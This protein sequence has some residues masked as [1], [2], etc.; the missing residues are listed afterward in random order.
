[1]KLKA[2]SF[3]VSA[4]PIKPSIMLHARWALSKLNHHGCCN[5]YLLLLFLGPLNQREVGAA[6]VEATAC[7]P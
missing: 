4:Y 2:G 7:L 6:S 1:M 5:C 3:F